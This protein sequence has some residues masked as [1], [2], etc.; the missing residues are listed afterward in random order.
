MQNSKLV[1]IF[2][3]LKPWK[4]VALSKFVASPYFNKREDIIQL[5]AYLQQVDPEKNPKLLDQKLAYQ[6]IYGAETPFESKKIRYAMSFLLQAIERFLAIEQ[7]E[8]DELQVHLSTAKAYRKLDLRKLYTKQMIKVNKIL[9]KEKARDLKW[10]ECKYIVTQEQFDYTVEQDRLEVQQLQQL[11]SIAVT[12]F[13]VKTLK[14]ACRLLSYREVLEV[15]VDTNMVDV[16]VKHV[17]SNPILL[18]QPLIVLY[19]Y[20]YKAIQ[21]AEKSYDYFQKFKQELLKAHHFLSKKELTRLYTLAVDYLGL[22]VAKLG[23]EKKYVAYEP[24]LMETLTLHKTALELDLF[25][26]NENY[27]SHYAFVNIVYVGAKAKAY[28]WV[29]DF[30]MTYK[31]KLAPLN[32]EVYA[33]ICLARLEFALK[34]Y[35]E[36]VL[37]LRDIESNYDL[38]SYIGIKILLL[39]TYYELKEFALLESYLSSF[40]KLL[41][42]KK[43]NIGEGA[44]RHHRGLIKLTKK[45]LTI[46]AYEKEQKQA[47]ENTI[48]SSGVALTLKEWLLEKLEEL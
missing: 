45:L 11:S 43:K 18:Q 21:R 25:F 32:R 40:E 12:L 17:E 13:I 31:D 35:K 20:Y 29:R 23:A 47:F 24:Y 26:D 30:I 37:L 2:Y 19:Y 9:E 16:I 3:A 14:H 10:W 39:K 27:F 36:V 38:L 4:Q 33:R 28:D 48:V 8:E 7:L 15:E 44:Y 42:R 22:T 1:Q 6:Y 46:R 5:C 34:N 41:Y